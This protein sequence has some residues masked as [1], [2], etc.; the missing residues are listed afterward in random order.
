MSSAPPPA[1]SAPISPTAAM[2]CS[3]RSSTVRARSSGR[4]LGSLAR[5][6]APPS[7]HRRQWRC[8]RRRH[9]E[10]AV[11]RQS[12]HRQ[13]HAR[14]Q[15]RRQWR[16]GASTS[17]RQLGNDTA[18]CRSP[19]ARIADRSMSAVSRRRAAATPSSPGS[20]AN[21]KLLAR[22][23][24]PSTAAAAT[25][26][27]RLPSTVRASFLPSPRKMARPRCARIDA[28]AL[29]SDLGSISLGSADARAIAVSPPPVRSPWS[30]RP[31]AALAGAQTNGLSG[32]RDG[33][34][35]RIRQRSFR[36]QHHLYR[37]GR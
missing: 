31:E 5:R 10:G 13:R 24:G 14:R 20:S 9:G 17:V 3:S 7:R 12:R 8:R 18:R 33:F 21:G 25:A 15:V 16:R 26:S 11:Q 32:G 36:R 23:G 34:V 22:Y 4:G 2:I 1:I 37:L 28:G 19:S 35:T 6:R 30:A 27:P 29:S